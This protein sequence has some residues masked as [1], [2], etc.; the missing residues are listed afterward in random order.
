VARIEEK[1]TDA[2][3]RQIYLL[4][5]SRF[6]ND[7][8]TIAG[9]NLLTQDVYLFESDPSLSIRLRF[10]QQR[11]L[12]RLAQAPEKGLRKERSVRIRSQLIKEIGNE[13]EFINTIDQVNSFSPSP[14]L[15]DLLSNELRTRFSYRP[16]P[17]WEVSYGI[18]VSRVVNRYGGGDAR[19]D[20]N[21]QFVGLTYAFVGVGQ[22]RGQFTREEVRLSGIPSDSKQQLP[23][24]FTNGK[25]AGTTYLWQLALDYRVGRCVQ[26]S[27]NYS[28]RSEGGAMAVH[29]A[30]AEAKAFF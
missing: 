28:G 9:T 24:E 16:E 6:L 23:F 27:V 5:F 3:T 4:N 10:N 29:N 11:G 19:A 2:D 20:M 25:V 18:G 13:T 12:V 1:S 14:R 21:D 8:T 22:L 15:R 26:L 17:A 30:R 7:Q